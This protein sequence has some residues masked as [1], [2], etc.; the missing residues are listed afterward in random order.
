MMPV[1]GG[2]TRFIAVITID[3]NQ[4]QDAR[5]VVKVDANSLETVAAFNGPLFLAHG[6]SDRLVPYSLSEELVAKRGGSTVFIET[7]ADHLRSHEEDP[8]RYSIELLKF[9]G[10]LRVTP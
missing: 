4:P 7:G 2:F 1:E 9:L 6:R 5:A 10:G 3:E 8:N